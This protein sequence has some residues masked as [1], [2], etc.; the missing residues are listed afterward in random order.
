MVFTPRYLLAKG[1]VAKEIRD[2]IVQQER[3]VIP[4]RTAHTRKRA[5][6]WRRLDGCRELRL[7]HAARRQACA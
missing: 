2:T 1:K 7:C 4:P 6:W 5:Q 3:S